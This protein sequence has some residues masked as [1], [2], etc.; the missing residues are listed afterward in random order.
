MTDDTITIPRSMIMTPI[1]MILAVPFG[2]LIGMVGLVWRAWWILPGWAWFI[3]PLGVPQV[4][5][6]HFTG[7]LLFVSATRVRG[8]FKK[9][10]RK[11][12]W[13]AIGAFVIGPI[14]AWLMMKWIA[15]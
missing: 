10:D 1:A 3:V 6:W 7:V 8:D 13:L 11:T 5:F 9:D 14:V 12:D 4:S 15:S 2:A